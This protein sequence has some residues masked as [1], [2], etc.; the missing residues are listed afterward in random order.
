MNEVQQFYRLAYN[1][2]TSDCGVRALAVACATPYRVALAAMADVGRKSEW[3]VNESMLERAAE[4]IGYEMV[5][6]EKPGK[7]FLTAERALCLEP[8]GHI[9]TSWDHAVGL[10]NGEL[11]D[12]TRGS[13]LRVVYAFKV[14]RRR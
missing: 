6:I 7:T 3:P 1:K 5:E 8:G 11:I 4:L 14:N 10:W 12:Y 9:L 2:E 13:R